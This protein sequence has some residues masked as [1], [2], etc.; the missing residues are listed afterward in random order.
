VIRF[1]SRDAGRL[2]AG[3]V[4][5]VML[6]GCPPDHSVKLYVSLGAELP[7]I[8]CVERAVRSRY[9]SR[10]GSVGIDPPEQR[11]GVTAGFP[12]LD[13][14][15]GNV[16]LGIGFVAASGHSSL[17]VSASW[18]EGRTPISVATQRDI[19]RNMAA[20]MTAVLRACVSE[21]AAATWT[22]RCD[23]QGSRIRCPSRGDAQ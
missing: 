20:T 8:A 23:W 18:F 6:C 1:R 13:F 17:R 15:E 4:V 21:T 5:T 7:T 11:P 14:P 12:R 16:Y 3:M 22:G 2:V 9:G 10:T 19:R